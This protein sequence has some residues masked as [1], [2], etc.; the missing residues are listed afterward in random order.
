MKSATME[1][2]LSLYKEQLFERAKARSFDDRINWTAFVHGPDSANEALK[3]IGL[4][5]RDFSEY[6]KKCQE[7]S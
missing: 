2:V 5:E 1:S 6:I 4:P 7:E 3:M